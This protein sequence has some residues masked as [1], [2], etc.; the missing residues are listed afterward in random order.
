MLRRKQ[1]PTKIEQVVDRRV[2]TQ[3]SLCLAR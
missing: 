3:E 2:N 1:V